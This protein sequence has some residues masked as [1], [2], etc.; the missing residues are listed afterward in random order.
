MYTGGSPQL[1][2]TRTDRQKP[3][4]PTLADRFTDSM[5]VDC[6]RQ[7]DRQT[8]L[9]GTRTHTHTDSILSLRPSV[10]RA[11]LRIHSL[12]WRSRFRN[13][14]RLVV[15]CSMLW[16]AKRGCRRAAGAPRARERHPPTGTPLGALGPP[17]RI[18]VFKD[19]F[20]VRP[21]PPWRC[22]Q[23]AQPLPHGF[24]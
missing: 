7:T 6:L 5:D 17:T 18:C 2:T 19:I 12:L 14:L 10:L 22:P 24:T 21:G 23:P 3:C 1:P 9:I 4:A 15:R 11:C 16:H 20:T 13:V 8:V